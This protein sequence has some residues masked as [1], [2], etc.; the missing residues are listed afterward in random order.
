MQPLCPLIRLAVQKQLRL[1]VL[2]VPYLHFH[3]TG[4]NP[5][6]VADLFH[7]RI[8][9]AGNIKRRHLT[10]PRPFKQV[11]RNLHYLQAGL[12]KAP[13]G[14]FQAVKA[15]AHSVYMLLCHIKYPLLT[16]E[17]IKS[18]MVRGIQCLSLRPCGQLLIALC[19][20]HVSPY[21]SI[22]SSMLSVS[23]PSYPAETISLFP[24]SSL[25]SSGDKA[26]EIFCSFPL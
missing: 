1:P 5:D 20:I 10:L 9:H 14:A 8:S 22:S 12:V 2:C 15:N 25:V 13:Q 21:L 3:L 19:L 23:I 7:V 24:A 17:Q 16:R 11:V 26:R 6:G 4:R 18:R